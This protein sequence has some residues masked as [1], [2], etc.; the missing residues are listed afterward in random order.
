M[1]L[2]PKKPKKSKPRKKGPSIKKSSQRSKETRQR[3]NRRR[4]VIHWARTPGAKSP[5]LHDVPPY[6]I[7]R[8]HPNTDW[9]SCRICL[10]LMYE[11]RVIDRDVLADNNEYT[12]RKNYARYRDV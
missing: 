8:I 9:T 2:K 10:R 7:P 5:E 4:Q 11:N 6:P 3:E 1:S 12:R